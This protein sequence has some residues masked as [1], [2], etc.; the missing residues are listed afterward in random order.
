MVPAPSSHRRLTIGTSVNCP[1]RRSSL[2]WKYGC[3]LLSALLLW[4]LRVVVCVLTMNLWVIDLGGLNL[5]IYLQLYQTKSYHT[6]VMYHIKTDWACL[7]TFAVSFVLPF[8]DAAAVWEAFTWDHR[9]DEPPPE[10][11][12]NSLNLLWM[13]TVHS[14][15][16]DS[17]K[18]TKLTGPGAQRPLWPYN[19]FFFF[20]FFTGHQG[21]KKRLRLWFRT[22]SKKIKYIFSW[23]CSATAPHGLP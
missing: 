19:D 10:R 2:W 21:Q 13:T 1:A 23:T 9:D 16:C 3:S 8:W 22:I 7:C 15:G 4:W 20:F 12:T 17:C 14:V 18:L 11:N 6:S 5:W